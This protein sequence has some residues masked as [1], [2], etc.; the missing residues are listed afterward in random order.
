MPNLLKSDLRE[1]H[2]PYIGGGWKFVW[3]KEVD[4]LLWSQ[5]GQSSQHILFSS[6]CVSVVCRSV[7]KFH[8]V[9][10]SCAEA[11]KSFIWCFCRVQKHE[12]VSF[13]VSV[14][15]R[16]MKKFHLVF[17]SC[18]EAR[19]SSIWC[20]WRVQKHE[21]AKWIHN[22]FDILCFKRQMRILQNINSTWWFVIQ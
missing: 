10:L 4:W 3:W 11:W 16:S 15:C 9:L 21:K 1:A 19:K 2:K 22:A 7:K 13:G 12:K 5:F 6:N 20:F 8:L 14:V 17:L 18:A